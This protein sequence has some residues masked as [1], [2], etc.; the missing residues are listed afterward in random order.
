MLFLFFL[1]FYYHYCLFK[2][3]EFIYLIKLFDKNLDAQTKKEKEKYDPENFIQ[4]KKKEEEYF[5]SCSR[6]TVV[7]GSIILILNA[8]FFLS[9]IFFFK[10]S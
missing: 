2:K 6:Q 7:H 5:S 8:S 4:S 3:I 9:N 10:F 1:L